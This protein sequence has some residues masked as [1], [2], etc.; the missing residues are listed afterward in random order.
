M[1]KL[2]ILSDLWGKEKSHWLAHYTQ[3]LEPHFEIT[4]YDV[5]ELGA[6]DKT[7]Y[8]QDALH[9]QFV[10]GGIERAVQQLAILEK[11][12][13]NILAFSIGG[14]IAWKYGLQTANIECLYGV[15]ATRLRK[16]TNQPTGV[17]QLYFGSE[18]TFNPSA[19]WF[20]QM[21]LQIEIIEGG[22]HELYRA[23]NFA[24]KLCRSFVQHLPGA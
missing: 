24:K 13:T 1:P 18:D 14:V 23:A 12:K 6:V 16:E 2:I 7:I 4:Y 10:N 3:Y 8:T 20:E 17:I 22:K 9:Q 21:H 11:E 15:S 5:C 19:N